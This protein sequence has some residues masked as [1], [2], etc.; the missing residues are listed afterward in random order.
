MR[1][2]ICLSLLIAVHQCRH[3]SEE[4]RKLK[5][6]GLAAHRHGGRRRHTDDVAGP[7]VVVEDG[8]PEWSDNEYQPVVLKFEVHFAAP[9][10][11]QQR[12]K[13]NGGIGW[14][15]T[16][17]ITSSGSGSSGFIH[18]FLP[19]SLDSAPL[20]ATS[21]TSRSTPAVTA[22]AISGAEM[23]VTHRPSSSSQAYS[24]RVNNNNKK[25]KKK[26][27]RKK[28]KVHQQH[29]DERNTMDAVDDV[30]AS[31]VDRRYKPMQASPS[32]RL[33]PLLLQDDGIPPMFNSLSSD[34][35]QQWARW[36]RC[37]LCL[38]ND[39]K[40]SDEES[41]LCQLQNVE[42]RQGNVT[43]EN[44]LTTSGCQESDTCSLWQRCETSQEI[45]SLFVA[46][47]P[48]P[49]TY[50]TGLVYNDRVWDPLNRH[51]YRW[52][53][54]S[55]Q[56]ERVDIYRPGASYCIRSLSVVPKMTLSS[57]QC[58][59]DDRRRLLT[60]GWAAGTPALVSPEASVHLSR[61]TERLPW[62][63]CKGDFSR[64][65]L[66][67]PPDNRL[68]CSVN[69]SDEEYQRQVLLATNY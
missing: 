40:Q 53:E 57:Q 11:K 54:I 29:V 15:R 60:R 34:E 50:P 61:V 35:T 14:N 44:E 6:Q 66:Q 12:K 41:D 24:R 59:Y 9:R 65:H 52:R 30:T 39:R 8:Q 42:C 64:Y 22:A 38:K 25:K 1:L 37:T 3:L 36:L 7:T 48:C 16:N 49:C 20:A 51:H 32:N 55:L 4:R 68:N 56:S 26:T 10:R 45:P 27:K 17:A 31:V 5:R 47:P 43:A 67:R 13:K 28:K 69:P 21:T 33:M 62:L 2:L 18:L 58:C 23:M 63:A 19:L 46:L